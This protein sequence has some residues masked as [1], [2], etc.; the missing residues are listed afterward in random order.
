MSTPKPQ[1]VPNDMPVRAWCY[2]CGQKWSL[3]MINLYTT[4]KRCPDCGGFT[5][6]IQQTSW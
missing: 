2:S 5:D 3:L 4:H 6:G 1:R